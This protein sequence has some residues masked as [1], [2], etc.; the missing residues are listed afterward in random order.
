M[1][2]ING[3]QGKIATLQRR[4]SH[5]ER[6]LQKED[7]RYAKTASADFDMAEVAALESATE[8]MEAYGVAQMRAR[9]ESKALTWLR[10]I[11]DAR[12]ALEHYEEEHD[13]EDEGIQEI[14]DS[15]EEKL[16]EHLRDAEEFVRSI[17]VPSP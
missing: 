17:P 1:K 10:K 4:K 13:E 5:L 3:L 14:A 9:E 8:A 6:R 12:R 15:L 11:L 16:N 7:D 2:Y